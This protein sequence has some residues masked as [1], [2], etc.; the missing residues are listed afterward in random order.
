MERSDTITQP[1]DDEE[2]EVAQ[3]GFF[4]SGFTEQ[5]PK[6]G[7]KRPASRYV[8]ESQKQWA[9]DID[10]DVDSSDNQ[11]DLGKIDLKCYENINDK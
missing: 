1:M 3:G 7:I 9:D 2:D 6:K 11:P 4:N 8:A 5:T 10:S